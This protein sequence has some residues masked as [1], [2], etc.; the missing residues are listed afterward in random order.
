M[1]TLT[2]SLVY[3]IWSVSAD[4]IS[5]QWQDLRI[6]AQ[7][8]QILRLQKYSEEEEAEEK[9]GSETICFSWCG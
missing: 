6:F 1:F 9:I 2:T 3:S 8:F 5:M 4:Q 7:I